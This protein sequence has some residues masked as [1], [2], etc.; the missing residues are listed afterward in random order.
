MKIKFFFC[1]IGLLFVLLFLLNETAESKTYSPGNGINGA[2]SSSGNSGNTAGQHSGGSSRCGA[3]NQ[4]PSLPK[5]G[6]DKTGGGRGRVKKQKKRNN[7]KCREKSETSKKKKSLSIPGF[8]STGSNSNKPIKRKKNSITKKITKKTIKAAEK[9]IM[10]RQYENKTEVVRIERVDD[11]PLLLAMMMQMKTHEIIDNYIP[12]HW[13][14]RDLSWGLTLII[15]LAYILSEGDHRKVSVREYVKNLSVSLSMIT[16]QNVDELDFTDDRLGVLLKYLS[17]DSYWQNIEKDFSGR[18]IEAYKLPVEIVR[19]DATTVSGNHE[20]EQGGLFQKGISKDNPELPQIK[21]MTGALDPL[22]MPLAVDIVSGETADDVLYRPVIKRINEYLK[23]ND[24]MYVG[25]S[26]MSAFDTRLYIKG[27]EQHYLCPMPQTGNTARNMDLW[28]KIGLMKARRNELHEIY[29]EKDDKEK[30]IARGYE[31]DRTLS[32]TIDGEKIEWSERVLIVNSPSHAKS[33]AE[34]LEK[35]LAAAV[36]KIYALTP[37]RGPGKRQISDEETLK[38]S[39]ARI[40]KQHKVEGMLCC[41]YEKEVEY[42]EKYVGRGKGSADRP[43]KIIEKIRYQMIK[44][45]RNEYRIKKEKEKQGW[46]VFVT[47]VSLK[48]LDFG[49]VVKCYRQEYRVERIFNR[50]KSR[51]N[52]DPLFVKR[53]DQIKGKTNLLTIGAR[54]LTLVEYIVRR[55]LQNDNAKLKGLHPEN[56]KKLTDTPTSERLLKVFS[57]IN[58][59]FLKTQGAVT[60]CMTQL[61]NLQQE[62]LKRLGL[63]CAVYKKLEITKSPAVLNEW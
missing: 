38:A 44:V 35:R 58:L 29:M 4:C 21:I 32:G 61:T 13:K 49:G 52:I 23:N 27:I 63:Q 14:Q 53:D 10:G 42:E 56:P 1:F 6:P 36:E 41:K 19:C 8:L 30:L 16:G 20:I 2:E 47:D 48:R 18:S 62:I 43:R 22:G 57:N 55:S 5:P 50:L 59:T 60:Q 28:I 17:I 12:M 11:I 15:W 40:L 31:F 46:K 39:I 7:K 37:V 3:A 26:K 25:D 45:Q 34:G 9:L 54:V 33:Q 24:T 51:M